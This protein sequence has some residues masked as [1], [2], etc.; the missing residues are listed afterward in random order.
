MPSVGFSEPTGT[1]DMVQDA[2][3]FDFAISKGLK[4]TPIVGKS[5]AVEF[6][7]LRLDPAPFNGKEECIVAEIL[8]ELDILLHAV[9]VAGRVF[10]DAAVSDSSGALFPQPPIAVEVVPL[11]LV[12]CDGCPPKKGARE[13]LHFFLLPCRLHS[14]A[15]EVLPWRCARFH[16]TRSA[17]L[18]L[19]DGAGK[20]L[21][22]SCG[23]RAMCYK[24]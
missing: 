10:R 1:G 12:T 13:L 17:P 4:Y 8:R 18:R 20:F 23:I 9:P 24:A 16:G 7:D 21:A 15:R 19:K 14:R 11:D 22:S 5:V 2:K 3:S 6:S